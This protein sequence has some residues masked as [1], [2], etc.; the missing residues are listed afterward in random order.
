MPAGPLP[1]TTTFLGRDAGGAAS[2][3][4]FGAGVHRAVDGES[5]FHGVDAVFARDALADAV[6]AAGRELV[7]Q[8]G[9]GEHR[10]AHRDEVDA[11]DGKNL[12]GTFGIVDAADGDHRH[13][14]HLLDGGGGADVERVAV[15]GGVDHAGDQPVDHATADVEGV[16]ACGHQLRCHLGGFEHR[17]AAG[18]P[19][20]AGDAQCD[21]QRVADLRPAGGERLEDHADAAL[22]RVAAVLVGAA[23]ALRRQERAEEHVAVRG[24]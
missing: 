16:G 7:R 24:V 5:L 20:V 15:V 22:H 13:I 19:F 11:A 10:A 17:P 8:L 14:D 3:L 18:D 21:R 4:S 12:L 23:V 1:I 2:S 6:G 9:I